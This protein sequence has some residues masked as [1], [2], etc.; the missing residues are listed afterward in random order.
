MD[1]E[2]DWYPG[3]LSKQPLP[4]INQKSSS[5]VVN[6]SV[7]AENK[8]TYIDSIGQLTPNIDYFFKQRLT[9]RE[10]PSN[11]GIEGSLFEDKNNP[12]DMVIGLDFGTSSVK[13]VLHDLNRNVFYAV[14]FFQVGI[15]NPYIFPSKVYLNHDRYSLESEDGGNAC[16]D[17][18]MPLMGEYI[19]TSNLVHTVAFLALIIRH[20]RGWLFSR[21][22]DVYL[23]TEIV[24]SLNLGLPAAYSENTKMSKQFKE[25]ALASI[26]L[27]QHPESVLTK[28]LVIRYLDFSRGQPSQLTNPLPVQDD[29]VNVF[30]EI[31]AQ[32]LAFIKSESWD[33]KNRPF[34]TLVD[35]GAGTV[36]ISFFSVQ[37]NERQLTFRFF[38]NDVQTNGVINL[39]RQR[40][41]WLKAGL[42][43][44]GL[45]TPT[46][47]SFFDEI[48]ASTDQLLAIPENVEQY[49]YN[50]K[51]KGRNIDF[52]FFKKY[53]YQVYGLLHHTR[54]NRL[55]LN[56]DIWR[57]LPIFLTGGGS[58]MQF[59]Q[60]VINDVNSRESNWLHLEPDFLTKPGNLLA[61]GLPSNEYDR[62]SVAYGLSFPQIG[63]I[64]PSWA[65]EDARRSDLPIR[66]RPIDPTDDG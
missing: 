16:A 20:A 26:N 14:P 13:V 56:N 47:D 63:K 55:P 57:K 3:L 53:K 32:V 35:I 29:M 12:T 8:E 2:T 30:P 1:D 5:K 39:H 6:K 33:S 15:Y 50:L 10:I 27:S 49:L 18:K 62:L 58:R 42:L 65:I 4:Y 25:I 23:S 64:V 24:W 19:N 45:L 9:N 66:E 61:D 11:S 54:Q 36:D 21:H 41:N 22:R 48:S 7:D 46:I 52:D 40:T 31:G 38:Q 17:L 44:R 59:Y 28:D 43:N 34:I 51:L 60:R 37:K